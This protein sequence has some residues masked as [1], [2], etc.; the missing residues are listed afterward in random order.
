VPERHRRVATFDFGSTAYSYDF[1]Q[2]NLVMPV[3]WRQCVSDLVQ[4]SLANVIEC[5][6]LN[7]DCGQ[8]DAL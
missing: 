7:I 4:Q 8:L 1:F 6:V 5:V 2:P 3:I